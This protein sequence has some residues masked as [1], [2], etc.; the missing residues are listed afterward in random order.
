MTRVGVCDLDLAGF[1]PST[2]LRAR[3]QAG[4]VPEA[5][6]RLVSVLAGLPLLQLFPRSQSRLAFNQE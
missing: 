2:A 5:S 4:I 1:C 6:P 3:V